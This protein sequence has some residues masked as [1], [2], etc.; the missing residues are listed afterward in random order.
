MNGSTKH[1]TFIRFL[2]AFVSCS[3]APG[4]G[5]QALDLGALKRLDSGVSIQNTRVS[6]NRSTQQTIVTTAVTNTAASAIPAPIYL[7]IESVSPAGV[8]CANADGLTTGGRPYFQLLATGQLAAGGTIS[9]TVGFANPNRVAITLLWGRIRGGV[10]FVTPDHLDAR[11]R[12][13]GRP[14]LQL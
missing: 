4:Y 7:I 6:Y 9:E 5:Q 3:T 10:K 13:Y 11:H 1:A 12:R 14:W 8:A 2:F